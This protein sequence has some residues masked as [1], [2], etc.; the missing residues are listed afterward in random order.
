MAAIGSIRKYSG[1]LIGAIGVSLVGFL[2]MDFTNSQG[3]VLKGR[4]DTVGKVY[5]DK[6]GILDFNKKYDENLKGAEEQMRGQ[7]LN[8]DQRNGI[9]TQTWNEMVNKIIFDRVY[10]KLGINV[11]PEEMS[12]LATGTENASPSITQVPGFQNPQTR[13]FDPQQVRLFLS[14][15]DVDDE[16]AEPGSKRRMWM[17]F[18]TSLKQ[19]QYQQKYSNLITKGLYVPNWMAEMTYNNSKRLADFKY[20]VLPYTEVSDSAVKV[21]DDDIKKYIDA[22]AARFKQ[23]EETRKFQ[24]VTFD[25]APSAGDT[26]HVIASLEEKR[27]EFAKGENPSADSLFVKLYSE[28]PFDEVYYDK[29]KLYSS[30]KDSFFSLPVKSVV[31]PY[32][33]GKNAKLAKIS[34]RKM[35]SDSLHLREIVISF[36]GL[37]QNDQEKANAKFRLVDSLVREIDTLKG[38]FNM[39]AMM[40]SDDTR[41]KMAG[42]DI[43]WVK[44]GEREKYYNDL[45]FYRAKKGVTYKIPVQ[46]ENAIHLVQIVEDRP[47]KTAVQ[48]DRKSTRLN[49]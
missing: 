10:D 20:V 13:Q 15:L 26:A 47:S 32:I 39:L 48:V 33:E 42:G 46:S 25:I 37:T 40:H 5:G 30:V 14:R 1:F 23:E 24:Y 22:H 9:R 35:I 44:Q 36:A 3:S 12:E 19:N 43:G 21:S 34:D 18:E 2:V 16:G 28:T 11:T 4:K 29:E 49:S 45:M 27:E 41:S 17:R 7:A 8:D 31:G 38:N 6:I